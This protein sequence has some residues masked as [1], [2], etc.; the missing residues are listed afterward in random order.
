MTDWIKEAKN[1]LD[2][3]C[4]ERCAG[5]LTPE[6]KAVAGTVAEIIYHFCEQSEQFAMAYCQGESFCACTRTVF[7]PGENQNW[8]ESICEEIVRFYMPGATVKKKISVSGAVW[9]T[10]GG[11]F[12]LDVPKIYMF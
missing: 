1:K 8:A 9:D 12:D 4:K 6:E 7:R 10:D 2:E 5:K 3:E 11:D